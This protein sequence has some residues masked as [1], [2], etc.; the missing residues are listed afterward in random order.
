MSL[1]Q[2]LSEESAW[3][4]FYAYKTSL[5][6]HKSM[7]K[8]LPQFIEQRSYLPVCQQIENSMDFP[9]PC[10]AV[11]NKSSSSRKRVVYAYPE[12][13]NTVL[14]LLT[15]LLIRQYDHLFAGNLYSFRPH[16]TAKD[17]VRRIISLSCRQPMY[18]YK[19]DISNYFNSIPA[20]RFLPELQQVLFDDPQLYQ[21][22]SRLLT[23][24]AVNADGQIIADKKGIMAGTPLSSFYANVYLRELDQW[25]YEQRIPYARYSDDIIVLAP[26]MNQVQDHAETIRHF[27]LQRELHINPDKESFASPAEGWTFLG[28]CCRN[29]TIDIAPVTVSKIKHKMRRKARSLRRWSDRGGID[30]RKAAAAFIR[31]FNRKLIDEPQDSELSWSKWFFS[32]INTTSSLQ[33]IDHYAQDCLR[34]L[35]SGSRTKSRY[36]IRYQDLKSLGYQSLVNAYYRYLPSAQCQNDAGT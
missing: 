28:F 23:A 12:P 24:P 17:A 20:S 14:K 34:F 27:L 6:C 36:N 15:Y 7:E 25:F 26:E 11:I 21:F 9:L 19:A 32:V 18:M 8:D 22:L 33:C 2:R 13:H 16:R 10:R 1:L 30:S 31:I 3:Q 4:Q 35:I 29:G 5:S